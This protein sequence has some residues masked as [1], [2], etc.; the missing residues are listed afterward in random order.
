M[1]VSV[2][3]FVISLESPAGELS[4]CLLAHEH[5]HR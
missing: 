2:Y 5:S 4:V 1:D 3:S